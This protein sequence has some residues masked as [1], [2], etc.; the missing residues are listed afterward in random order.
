MTWST[1]VWVLLIL[2]IGPP[3]VDK[4]VDV[5][6]KFQCKE[7]YD[8]LGLP[9]DTPFEQVR[10]ADA[11]YAKKHNLVPHGG[12]MVPSS[13]SRLYTVP[14]RLY[15]VPP[16]C[17][18]THAYTSRVKDATSGVL[19]VTFFIDVAGWFSGYWGRVAKNL[20]GLTVFEIVCRVLFAVLI[21]VLLVVAFLRLCEAGLVRLCCTKKRKKKRKKRSK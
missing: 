12:G 6:H 9:L 3:V 4:S 1:V 2:V 8:L 18:Y 13:T 20:F 19:L 17:A 7:A 5:V 10:I 11:A 14:P 15:T 21:I 16:T